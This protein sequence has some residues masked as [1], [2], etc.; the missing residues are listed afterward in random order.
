LD[1]AVTDIG[2]DVLIDEPP[3][4]TVRRSPNDVAHALTALLLALAVWGISRY[5]TAG[6]AGLEQDFLAQVRR[7][8]PWMESALVASAQIVAIFAP[9]IAS[10]YLLARRQFRRVA[11]LWL[12]SLVA[13]EAMALIQHVS[14]PRTAELDLYRSLQDIGLTSSAPSPAVIAGLAAIVAVESPWCTRRWR[15]RMR[16]GLSVL[17]LVRLAAGTALPIDVLQALSIGWLIGAL[18]LI[19]LGAPNRQARAADVIAALRTLGLEA[20]EVSIHRA[21]PFANRNYRVVT[22]TGERLFVKII[23]DDDRDLTLPRRLYRWIRLRD[24][25]GQGPLIARDRLVEREGFA[26]LS[27]Y[28]GEVPTPRLR[29]VVHSTEDVTML[30]FDDVP[31][32][33]LD[34]L[35]VD[36]VTDAVLDASFAAVG[37]MRSCRIAHRD[38]EHR[39]VIVG[40]DGAVSLVDFDRAEVGASDALLSGDV[41][42]ML[43]LTSSVVGAERSARAAIGT[44][45]GPV[46]AAALPRLQ[47]LALPRDVRSAVAAEG[48]LEALATAVRAATGAP[49]VPLAPIERFKPRTI[50]MIA[51]AVLAI[52]ALA[53]QVTG[54]SQF[55]PQLRSANWGWAL[56]ATALSLLTYLGA[57]LSLRGAVPEPLPFRATFAVQVATSFTGIAAPA[58]IGGIGLNLRFLQR[59]GIDPAVASAAVGVNAV[60]AFAV[61]VSLL[62]GFSF[63]VGNQRADP[64][65]LPSLGIVGL[66]IGAVAVVIAVGLAVPVTRRLAIDKVVPVVQRAATGIA[67]VARRPVNVLMLFGGALI[68]TLGYFLALAVSLQAFGG[69]VAVATI[70]V[71]YLASTVLAAAAP[72]PGGLGAIEAALIGGLSAAGAS[73]ERALGAVL[74]F[75]L[76][77]FW[78]PILPGWVVFVRLQRRGAI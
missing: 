70:A 72:T 1:V 73:G 43:A 75:R 74:V 40:D 8:P 19:I 61:H 13:G 4:P 18:L 32:R 52:T 44:L 12:A 9:L 55:W 28:V 30:V 38:I 16:L 76:I 34:E 50:L 33:T 69:G 24:V 54:M 67:E 57:T 46:V 63:W 20:R 78:L 35:A 29:N 58:N 45:G 23:G 22:R 39:S 62:V 64:F 41:A 11:R 26:A 5:A 21:R 59:R 2:S 7:L 56:V 48:G 3:T 6:L 42:Q 71:V 60:A 66:V 31:G 14:N 53:P 51:L 65:Q 77:T 15:R 37:S 25:G 27:A 17:I 49:E 10:I 47:P 68:V 36:E